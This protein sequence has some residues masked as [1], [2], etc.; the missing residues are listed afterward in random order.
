MPEKTKSEKPK[1][2]AHTLRDGA[3]EVAIWRNESEKGPFFSVTHRRSYK[4]GDE[5]R[6]SDS[7]PKEDIL[8]LCKQL[9]LAHTWI[10]TELQKQ[11]SQQAA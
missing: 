6:D 11:R 4:Q 1:K 8:P 5:W 2:P 9:D 7:Y 3:I 10:L